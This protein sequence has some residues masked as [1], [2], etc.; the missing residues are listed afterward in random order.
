M[1]GHVENIGDAWSGTVILGC[2]VKQDADEFLSVLAA[3]SARIG[4]K[5]RAIDTL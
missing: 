1:N 2:K 3:P 4:V 5:K